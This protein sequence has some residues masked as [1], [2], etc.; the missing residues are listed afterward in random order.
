MT[1]PRNGQWVERA[2]SAAG[3]VLTGLFAAAARLRPTQKP[4][5]P[6]GQLVSGTIHRV[7]MEPRVGVPWID[8]PGTDTVRVRLS[9]AIGLPSGWP[10]IFGLAI[11]VPIS[12]GGHGDLLFASTGRSV[13]GRFVLVPGREPTETV[14]STLI[15]YRTPQGPLLLAV[16]P[17]SERILELACARPGGRWRSFAR[18]ELASSPEG[19]LGDAEE[20]GPSFD[21]VLNQI[22][23]L[24]YYPWA[25][26]LREGAY[27]AARGSRT[28]QPTGSTPGSSGP[29]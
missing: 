26:R 15:P 12:S 23:S 17:T 25:A 18:L 20:V 4:L 2:S 16:R 5:H 29:P 13:V 1:G 28:Q 19:D 10:D 11:R 22:P 6:R 27:R 8:E 21:P 24:E 3:A 9:R 14:Y 7:G